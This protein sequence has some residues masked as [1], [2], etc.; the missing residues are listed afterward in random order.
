MS[1]PLK[2]IG[3][4]LRH[5]ATASIRELD[6]ELFIG[7]EEQ[8]WNWVRDHYRNYQ[9]L[10]QVQTVEENCGVE[11]PETPETVDF[12]RHR[13]ENLR[14]YR[15]VR[16]MFN[17]LRS[18]LGDMD[19]EGIR[20]TVNRMQAACQMRTGREDLREIEELDR[21]L[22]RLYRERALTGQYGGDGILTGWQHIDED[23]QGYQNG[24]LVTWVAR[25]EMGKTY[26]WLKQVLHSWRVG[27]SGLV[28][29]M[30]MALIALGARMLGMRSGINPRNI[31][32]GR[33][34]TYALPRY[35]LAINNPEGVPDLWFYAGNFAKNVADI[36]ALAVEKAP[37]AI[38]IDGAY[39]LRPVKSSRVAGRYENIAYVIDE[40]KAMAIRLNRPVIITT[41]LGRGAGEKG[42]K[43]SLETIGYTD[44]IG[45]HSSL[46]YA[47]KPWRCHKDNRINSYER[48]KNYRVI[49]TLKG[50]EGES[51]MFPINYKFSPPNFN[52]APHIII[53]RPSD[54]QAAQQHADHLSY[55]NEETPGVQG[56]IRDGEEENGES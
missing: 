1:E 46:V 19:A 47:I 15:D 52:E 42:A 25:P 40:L 20:D 50:R 35:E 41:Q 54:D 29:S 12:Y 48:P 24:D 56:V 36:E 22:D 3:A 53:G 14:L 27:R 21:D 9:R 10:P 8:V 49:E 43:A 38:W 18:V 39:L 28:V 51:G 11:I 30:E 31:R 33:I 5:N 37:D 13:V 55:Q 23:T 26:L 4:V 2:L 16:P 44:A 32:S 45:T 17:D 34:S 7:E 6:D